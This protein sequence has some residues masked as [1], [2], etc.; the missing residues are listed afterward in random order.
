MGPCANAAK[1]FPSASTDGRAPRDNRQHTGGRTDDLKS[2][3][4]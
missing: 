3:P 2:L 1:A 4:G